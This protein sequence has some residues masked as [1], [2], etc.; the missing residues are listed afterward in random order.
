[1]IY[2]PAVF[3]RSHHAHHTST[4][5]THTRTVSHTRDVCTHTLRPAATTATTNTTTTTFCDLCVLHMHGVCRATSWV[6]GCLAVPRQRCP[7]CPSCGRI[8]QQTHTRPRMWLRRPSF[9]LLPQQA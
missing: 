1:M 4:H 6:V 8:A 7:S 3:G 9:T 2:V 5:I